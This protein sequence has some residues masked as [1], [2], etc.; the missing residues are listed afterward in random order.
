MLINK[1]KSRILFVAI[2]FMA[3][4]FLYA[5][6]SFQP[7]LERSVSLTAIKQPVEK[8]LNQLSEQA[9]C[10]FSYSTESVNVQQTATVKVVNKPVKIVLD[11][12]F[13]HQVG[14]KTHGKYIILK[15]KNFP[16]KPADSHI[17]EGYVFD[18]RTGKQVTEA[19]VYD[20]KLMLSAITDQYGYFRIEIPRKHPIP[21]LCISKE[22]YS[23]TLL[24]SG[25][26]NSSLKMMEVALNG[27]NR[28]KSHSTK[29]FPS[30]LVP[31]KLKI[32]SANL[33]DSIFR[34][35]QFSLFPMVNTNALL[36]GNTQND[37]SLNLTVGYVYAIRKCE[38][39][40]IVNIVRTNAGAC[41]LAGLGNIVGKTVSGFQAAGGFNIAHTVSGMQAAGAANIV[42]EK[43]TVQAAGAVN[44]ARNA[45]L[46]LS[47]AANIAKDTADVQLSGAINVAGEN[48]V[49]VSGAINI[50]KNSSF[51]L[52]GVVNLADKTEVQISTV[53]V[54]KHVRRLQFGVV[55]IA[56][57][58]SGI[59]IGFFS[60]VR[61]G[62]HRLEASIDESSFATVSY[63]SGV[64]LFHTSFEAGVAVKHSTDG[65]LAWGYGI[66]TSLGNARKMLF[67][68][69]L[70]ARQFATTREFL[71]NGNQFRLYCG[72]DRKIATHLSIALGL[73]YN[74]L[75]YKNATDSQRQAYAQI[76]PYTV[77]DRQ[78]SDNTHLQSWIGGKIALRFL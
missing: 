38:L 46:Q 59:P 43:A 51:Q 77:T 78:L 41:Q 26:L 27:N 71:P 30:W 58:C 14:Y 42:K 65:L 56:D 29:F 74:V 25:T 72:I 33:T 67:D 53:N 2:F 63:R 66:G 23:D 15:W 19:S 11:E 31:N 39:G 13:D 52:T 49:Q 20:R 5:Q 54:A 55:N 8:I 22:G 76:A 60:Y 32:H 10:V 36:T 35:V 7:Y 50:A 24:L 6:S 16:R 12:V 37:V 18:K 21:N 45:Q 70:S 62:Y 28:P 17:L 75:V 44:I 61:S 9:G 69:D 48:K 57:S 34:K 73:S 4:Q 68:I 3:F 64:P 47:G 1:N 40:G